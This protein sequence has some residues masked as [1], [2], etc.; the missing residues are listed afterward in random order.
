MG[1]GGEVRIPTIAKALTGTQ[2]VALSWSPDERGRDIMVREIS[3]TSAAAE[4]LTTRSR[5]VFKRDI[6]SSV[7]TTLKGTVIST[8]LVMTS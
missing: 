4:T 6:D 3:W 5:I 8:A 2:L 1:T 7:S